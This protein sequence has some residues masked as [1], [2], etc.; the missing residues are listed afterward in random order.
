VCLCLQE[1]VYWLTDFCSLS[2]KPY[3]Y[4]S[5]VQNREGFAPRAPLHATRT[6]T[7]LNCPSTSCQRNGVLKVRNRFPKRNFRCDCP[8]SA[9]AH[10]CTLHTQKESEN[11]SNQYGQ[12]FQAKFCRCGRPYDAK[13]ERETMIQCLSCEVCVIHL[14]RR[15]M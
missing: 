6:T 8:T 5:H 11:A 4:A 14:A 9:I 12:N 13:T 15:E 2:D 10:D 7:K 3:I 1:Y